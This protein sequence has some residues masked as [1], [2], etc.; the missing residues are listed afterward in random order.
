M[1]EAPFSSQFRVP[2]A[3]VVALASAMA[4]AAA[5]LV[6]HQLLAGMWDHG[7][8]WWRM[9]AWQL[10][11]WGFWALAAPVLMASGARLSRSRPWWRYLPI[12]LNLGL[13]CFL[14]QLLFVAAIATL[15]QPFIPV[16]TFTYPE[17]VA[18]YSSR[19]IFINLVSICGLLGAGHLLASNL[20]A[21]D[22]QVQESRLEAELVRAQLQALRLQIEPHFLFNTLNSIAAL[23]LRG[24]SDHALA[25][26]QELGGLLRESL[27]RA[28]RNVVALRA[29]LEFVNR[30]VNLQSTRFADR[31]E[32]RTELAEDCLDL[33]VPTFSLQTLVENSIRHGL[34]RSSALRV[35]IVAN[36][37]REQLHLEVSDD[38]P[39]L[40]DGFELRRD[41]GVGLGN[42]RSRLLHLYAGAAALQVDRRN[43]GGTVS[44]VILPCAE[45]QPEMTGAV[46]S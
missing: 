14:A 19:W 3:V 30:Y 4:A 21:R 25:T 10:A 36:R 39:G 28:S 43:G 32:V 17:F 9:Y 24:D 2:I 26:V 1:P 41:A 45:M 27:D 42:L 37:N 16:G 29:E 33:A 15:S 13:G 46:P 44:S 23:I 7:H 34:T 6:T 18:E 20:E 38:G 35:E 11:G 40:P 12:S 22:L 8:S 5:L 31:L